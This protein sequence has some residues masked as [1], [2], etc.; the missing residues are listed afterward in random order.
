MYVLLQHGGSQLDSQ[1]VFQNGT[2]APMGLMPPTGMPPL[3]LQQQYGGPVTAQDL[4]QTA[5]A[6][7]AVAADPMKINEMPQWDGGRMTVTDMQDKHVSNYIE[8]HVVVVVQLF[9]THFYICCLLFIQG[10]TAKWSQ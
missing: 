10:W 4:I 5:A 7:A 2:V 9:F 8:T 6:A 3:G 1:H